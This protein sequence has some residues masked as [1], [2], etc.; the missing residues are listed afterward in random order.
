[1]R[2][3]KKASQA[4]MERGEFARACAK[5]AESNRLDIQI[6][7]LLNQADCYEKAGQIA[8]A[9]STWRDAA[10]LAEQRADSRSGMAADRAK[11]SAYRG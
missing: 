2:Y 11:A 6:G 5:F 9:W 7:G 1:L 4:L 3:S 10:D 8:T